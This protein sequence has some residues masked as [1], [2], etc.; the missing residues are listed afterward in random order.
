MAKAANNSNDVI[1]ENKKVLLAMSGGVDSS[2]TAKLLQERGYEVTGAFMSRGVTYS[3]EGD[4]A[5]G[6]QRDA[7]DAQ[8]VADALGIELHVLDLQDKF[9]E[10]IDY[11]VAEYVAGRTPN[12][13]IQCNMKLKF[14]RLVAL[15]DSLGCKYMA[16]GHYA[17]AVQ[18]K[19][20]PAI[21]RGRNVKKDQSY[22]LFGI[23][24]VSLG[25]IILPMGEMDD[26]ARVREIAKSCG[27]EVHD[28]PDSQDICFIDG[29]D[30]TKLLAERG[31]EALKPG[32]IINT[33]GEELG[34][35]EGYGRYTIGQRRGLG[36]AMG[37]PAYVI[38]I[39]PVTA[40]VTL[41]SREEVCGKKL[42]AKDA[43]WQHQPKEDS[44]DA[45]VQIR[46]NHRGSEA[47]VTLTG[48]NT[49]D[50][51]FKEPIHA[52]TPGQAAVVYDQDVVL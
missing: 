4:V 30:Y 48:E 50:V 5:C 36:V 15:A 12:P 2:V 17:R 42:S 31:P 49:F 8:R 38:K 32:R 1:G 39:D 27:L 41:G 37:Q 14:G 21:G 35:H 6:S 23:A 29:T 20:S 25:R 40:D 13:C 46:Y 11:F 22:V 7:G 52:I 9:A 19:G 18:Y 24:P 26:K 43:R 33:A 34:R 47:R 51:E 10:I 44:F 16:T 45:S 28:K 3:P